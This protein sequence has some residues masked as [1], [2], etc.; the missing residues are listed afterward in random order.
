MLAIGLIFITKQLTFWMGSYDCC[1]PCYSCYYFWCCWPARDCHCCF[2]L[3]RRWRYSICHC[4]GF[5]WLFWRSLHRGHS[6]STWTSLLIRS[7]RKIQSR[8]RNSSES[9]RHCQHTCNKWIQIEKWCL[10][11]S[12]IW[13]FNSCSFS[14]KH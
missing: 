7:L 5:C 11:E 2:L 14:L 3:L 12:R 13:G 9:S 1:L 4:S 10:L 6:L 8:P